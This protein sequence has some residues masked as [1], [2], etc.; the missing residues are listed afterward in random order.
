MFRPPVVLRL[1]ETA[2]QRHPI[3][4]WFSAHRRAVA[5]AVVPAPR[6]AVAVAD[7]RS[8]TPPLRRCA[9]P[10]SRRAETVADVPAPRHAVAVADVPAPLQEYDAH[11]SHAERLPVLRT[12][13]PRLLRTPGSRSL[14]RNGADASSADPPSPG[15]AAPLAAPPPFRRRACPAGSSATTAPR[16]PLRM[17]RAPPSSA[18]ARIPD[19]PDGRQKKR[20]NTAG[21]LPSSPGYHPGV[22]GVRTRRPDVY[23]RMIKTQNEN[24][25]PADTLYSRVKCSPSSRSAC[26]YR[27]ML[28]AACQSTPSP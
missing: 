24:F 28:S 3:P 7:S 22:S 27:R 20:G 13:G 2:G 19:H 6:R 25:R 14:F 21:V 4:A 1:W 15:A 23:L 11:P 8:E 12:P 16:P 26:R 9:V 5:V 17:R 18:S 10:A